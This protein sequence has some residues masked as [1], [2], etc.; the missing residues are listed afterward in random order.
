MKNLIGDPIVLSQKEL[1]YM[2][3][4]YGEINAERNM[5]VATPAK[6]DNRFK[7]SV[8]KLSGEKEAQLAF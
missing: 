4:V 5:H 1:I 3:G 7:K 6:K 2:F 8:K